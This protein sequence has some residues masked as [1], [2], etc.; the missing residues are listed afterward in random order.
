MAT[1]HGA[2]FASNPSK[3]HDSEDEDV[4]MSNSIDDLGSE[5]GDPSVERVS[6]EVLDIIDEL[7]EY[8]CEVK[9][10]Y[11]LAFGRNDCSLISC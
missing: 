3:S 5:L 7:A 2:S 8:L 10:E 4:E 9:E 1:R 6:P 11:V